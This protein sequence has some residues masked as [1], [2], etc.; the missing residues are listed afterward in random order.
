MLQV[1]HL[2]ILKVDRVLHLSPCLLLPR[3][4]VSCSVHELIATPYHPQTS[5]QAKTSNKQIKNILQK[6]IEEMGTG[7]K[8]K[9]LEALWAYRIAYKNT[10]WCDSIPTSI[11]K[12]LQ[13]PRRTRI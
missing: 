8:N 5:G 9:L 13:S 1:L 6:T 10:H 3:L 4:S 12:D 2:N 7:W 11:L